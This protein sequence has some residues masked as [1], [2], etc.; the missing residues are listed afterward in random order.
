[1]GQ[2]VTRD[3]VHGTQTRYPI[4][5]GLNFIGSSKDVD[6]LLNVPGVSGFHAFIGTRFIQRE[7]LLKKCIKEVSEDGEEHFIEDLS[8]TNG[9]QVGPTH[10][11]LCEWK[12]YQLVHEKQVAF[13]PVQCVYQYV[14]VSTMGLGEE[15]TQRLDT[16][17]HGFF[18]KKRRD[19]E[20]E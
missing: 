4:R 18:L 16:L 1:M 6:V 11:Q 14:H 2:L 13:G 15:E 12:L 10:Y 3:V 17:V 19:I 20:W 5:T 7:R 8:S 9:T